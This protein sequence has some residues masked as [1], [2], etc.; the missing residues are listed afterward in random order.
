MEQFKGQRLPKF[1]VPKRYDL[2]LKPDLSACKF[3]GS[4]AVDLDIIADTKF[5]VLNAADLSLV[6]GSV[7][8]TNRGFSKVS[9]TV[10]FYARLSFDLFSQ[11]IQPHCR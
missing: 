9:P 6:T 10:P 2:S 5:I 8:F 3:A 7:S 4:V 11:G 1:A